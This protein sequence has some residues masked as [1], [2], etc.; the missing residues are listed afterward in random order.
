MSATELQELHLAD[1]HAR[2]AEAGIEGYRLLRRD[3]LIER[4]VGGEDEAPKRA[5][6]GRRGGR[7]RGGPRT[8][9]SGFERSNAE[10][11]AGVADASASGCRLTVSAPRGRH[12]SA[13][14]ATARR[15]PSP[16]R[17]RTSRE[18]SS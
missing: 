8:P 17:P 14:H 5:R 7:G 18:S 6:R 12:A 11:V 15:T 4:L 1:L 2:A 16:R 3:E 13:S 9:T 10:A